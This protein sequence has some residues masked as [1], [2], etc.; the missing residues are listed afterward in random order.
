[1][2]NDSNNVKETRANARSKC[3]SSYKNRNQFTIKTYI[4]CSVYVCMCVLL[5]IKS[6][7]FAINSDY[8]M[9]EI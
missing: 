9:F 5:M 2:D 7:F 1:M 8:D 4:F 6:F 3:L